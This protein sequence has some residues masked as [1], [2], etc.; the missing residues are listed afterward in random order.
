MTDN[1]QPTYEQQKAYYDTKWLNW[2]K[3][4]KGGDGICVKEFIVASVKNLKSESGSRPRIID[5]GCGRGQITD[6]LSRYGDVV[7]IDLSTSVAEKLHPDLKFIQ[8][9]I[10]TDELEGKYDIAVSS[11]VIEHLTFENQPIYVKKAYDLLNEAGYLILTTPNKPNI[12]TLVKELSISR[13]KLQPIENWLDR[14]SLERLLAPYFRIIYI[15]STLFEPILIRKCRFLHY[16]YVFVYIYLRLY[17]FI[18]R[19][20]KASQRGLY[21]TV[22]ARKQML[23]TQLPIAEK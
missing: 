5:L 10:V 21:L 8:A 6:L 15:G 18:N 23:G 4:K 3:Q 16:T 14:E 19:L 2:I 22:F 17:K 12:E 11:E 13:E 20:F 7:G 9:N 1:I